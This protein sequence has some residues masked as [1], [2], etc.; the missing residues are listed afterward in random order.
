MSLTK[1]EIEAAKPQGKPYRLADRDGL[2]LDVRAKSKSWRYRYRFVGKE[3][4]H[5]L[6]R[7][8]EMSR[9]EAREALIALRKMLAQGKSPSQE[10]KLERIR[11]AHQ[12]A[13]TFE[14]L[15]DEWVASR[16]WAETT[17]R[18]RLAQI[19]FHV[20]PYLGPLAIREITPMHVLDVLRKAEK[21]AKS[22]KK[23]GRGA[24][25]RDVGSPNVARRLRHYVAS[26]FNVAIATG[27][28]DSNPAGSL[29]E[30]LSPAIRVAHKT[31]LR[32]KQVGDF[33]RGLDAYR[34]DPKTVLAFRLLWWSMLRPGEV[35]AAHWNEFDLDAATWTIPRA[36]MKNKNPELPAHIVPLPSQ[37]VERLRTWHAFT[38]GIGYLFPHRDK[39]GQSMIASTLGKVHGRLGLDFPYSPHATRTT[40]ST[41]LNQMGYRYDAIEKQLDHEDRDAIR[42][43]YNRAD[44]LEERR[45]MMQQWADLL[46]EWKSG[47]KVIPVGLR[48]GPVA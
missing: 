16:T 21:P 40:A 25:V 29:R 34:G 42:R 20:L 14:A 9:D 15:F 8:P 6:G 27:R 7:Y 23:R 3:N 44:Y 5:T 38:G 46:D 11:V 41:H 2:Y 10:K 26:V 28:A 22:E 30:V 19:E 32:P 4:V 47:G 12:H 17:K 37:A 45:Q 48:K 36:R 13:Q 24:R 18:N 33:L 35:V 31:P 39:S 1:T 43:A